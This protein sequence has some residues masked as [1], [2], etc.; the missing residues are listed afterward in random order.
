M[1][2]SENPP[3]DTPIQPTE[4]KDESKTI[5]LLQAEVR[6]LRF[7]FNI[8]LLALVVLMASLFSFMLR[9]KKLVRQKIDE[10]SRYIVEYRSKMEP[11][12][13]E[14]G[15]K[16]SCWP[17]PWSRSSL[18]SRSSSCWCA[19]RCRSLTTWRCGIS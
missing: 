14:L 12:V 5:E 1:S 10:N 11:R 8:V 3:G 15:S 6:S 7:L 18:R 4:A 16:L 17:R 9:E 19:S 2:L 13:K